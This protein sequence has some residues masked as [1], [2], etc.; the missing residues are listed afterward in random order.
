MVIADS[1]NHR[2]IEWKHEDTNGKVIAG[3]N[4]RGN[5]LDQLNH[6]TDVLIDK[7]TD[8]LIICDQMNRRVVQWS[9][10]NNKKQ[11]EIL[12]D[13]VWCSRLALD[14]Q[15]YLYVSDRLKHEVRRYRLG[16]KNG[17]LVAGGNGPGR[18]LSQLNHPSYLFVDRQQTVYVSDHRNHRVMKWNK[19][20]KEGIIVAGG[21]DWGR[22]LAQLEYPQGIFVDTLGS[23]YVVDSGNNRVMRWSQGAKQGTIVVGGNAFRGAGEHQLD[24][25]SSLSFDQYGNLYVVDKNNHRIQQFLL[26]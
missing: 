5:R 18:S 7:K 20:A 6:P 1:S 12:I 3:G 15:R 17:L 25:P 22:A 11:G 14:D 19:D 21:R 4:G 13:S 8:N 23:V 2:I 24:E 10:R 26:E 9:R 16:D